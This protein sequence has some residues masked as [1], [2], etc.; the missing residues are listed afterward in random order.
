MLENSWS[1]HSDME[2]LKN[3]F[4]TPKRSAAKATKLAD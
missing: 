3:L 1:V 2:T 4:K